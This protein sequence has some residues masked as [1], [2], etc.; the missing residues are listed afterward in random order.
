MKRCLPSMK[1]VCE[2]NKMSNKT[3]TN[4]IVAAKTLIPVRTV[5]IT[6]TVQEIISHA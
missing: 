3:K 4:R 1:N 5:I 6:E 2:N